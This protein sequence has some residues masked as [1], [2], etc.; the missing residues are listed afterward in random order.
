MH[1]DGKDAE[2]SQI[3]SQNN[4]VRIRNVHGGNMVQ[5]IRTSGL[6]QEEAA[7]IQP[8]YPVGIDATFD[9]LTSSVPVLTGNGFTLSDFTITQGSFNATLPVGFETNPN[10]I[11]PI[12][13]QGIAALG[14][15]GAFSGGSTQ[16]VLFGAA[17]DPLGPF[18]N[19][20]SNLDD[21]LYIG[22][23]TDALGFAPGFVGELYSTASDAEIVEIDF[24]IRS[25]LGNFSQFALSLIHI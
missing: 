14:N 9:Q 21:F 13:Q 4:L 22:S 5:W 6:T 23:D 3:V 25:D 1:M 10:S 18:Q 2:V 11:D 15:S 20:P 24:R 16:G 19:G 7:M 12:F 8:G 17:G